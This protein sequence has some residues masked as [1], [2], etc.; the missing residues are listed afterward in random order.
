MDAKHKDILLKSRQFI[1]LVVAILL[2]RIV[3]VDLYH[4]LQSTFNLSLS[5]Y[6]LHFFGDYWT[7]FFSVIADC[8]FIYVLH[9]VI[10]YGENP[11][12][13]NL[14]TFVFLFTES[15]IGALIL[16]REVLFNSQQHPAYSGRIL[17]SFLAILLINAVIVIAADLIIFFRQSRLS[18]KV[19]SDKKRKAQYQYQQLKQQLNP[20]FLFNSLNVLDY[21]VQN[22]D[23]QRASDFIRKLAGVYR[24]LLDTGENKLVSIVEELHFIEMYTDLLKERFPEGLIL[25]I[26]VAEEYLQKQIIPCGLQVLVEN[27]TK[28]NIVSAD[29]PLYISIYVEHDMIVVKN[30]LQPRLT[31]NSTGLG[32]QNIQ[33]QYKDIANKEIIVSKQNK[34]YIVKLPI[35]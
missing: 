9:K 21:L 6:V 29:K 10:S 3:Y 23:K 34:D 18:L 31:A 8:G 15:F 17:I 5:D 2:F 14:A 26:D 4:Y 1:L 11:V 25:N 20:H 13:R 24:Y 22:E 27:A 19:E 12:K 32:L 28:H 33:K 7:L 16:N 35:L 30:N